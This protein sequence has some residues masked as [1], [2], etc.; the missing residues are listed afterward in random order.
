VT[1][2]YSLQAKKIQLVA[3]DEIALKTGSAEI[4][5]KKN[6]DIT[7]KGGKVN[8][9]ASGDMILKGSTIKEN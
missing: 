4:I 7:I 8:I 9:K 3:D 1:K 2:E 6:G 5:M